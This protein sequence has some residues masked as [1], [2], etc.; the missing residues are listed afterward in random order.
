MQMATFVVKPLLISLLTTLSPE[1]F[2]RRIIC[3]ALQAFPKHSQYH[4]LGFPFDRYF[5][6]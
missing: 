6:F 3:T 4:K 1:S 5:L 2:Q